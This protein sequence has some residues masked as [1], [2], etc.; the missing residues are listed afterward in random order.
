MDEDIFDPGDLHDSRIARRRTR[1]TGDAFS[2]LCSSWFRAGGD[3]L[4]GSINIA[5]RVA[6]DLTGSYCDRKPR[7]DED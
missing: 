6:E 7:R 4:V 5:G 2:H 1:R 3:M